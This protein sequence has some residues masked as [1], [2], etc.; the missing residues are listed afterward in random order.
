MLINDKLTKKNAKNKNENRCHIIK[1]N[2]NVTVSSY[3]LAK[4]IIIIITETNVIKRDGLDRSIKN[5]NFVF[6]PH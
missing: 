5:I 1:R 2:T 6:L 3:I 4:V